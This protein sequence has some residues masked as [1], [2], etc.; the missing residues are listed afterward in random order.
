MT[1]ANAIACSRLQESIFVEQDVRDLS[2]TDFV[3]KELIHFSMMVAA[4]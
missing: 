1:W 2:Y 4:R 3:N